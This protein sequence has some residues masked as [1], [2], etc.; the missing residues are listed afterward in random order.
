MGFTDVDL[1]YDKTWK[2]LLINNTA[3]RFL[4]VDIF[5]LH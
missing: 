2:K 4:L 1:C 5:Y 3:L